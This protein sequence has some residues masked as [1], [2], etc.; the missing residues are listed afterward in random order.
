M[1]FNASTRTLA[2]VMVQ[3]PGVPSPVG[4]AFIE[5]VREVAQQRMAANAGK[6]VSKDRQ[7]RSRSKVVSR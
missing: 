4:Q 2:S 5:A 3:L 1:S 7:K 6:V